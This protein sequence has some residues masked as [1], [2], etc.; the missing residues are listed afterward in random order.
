MAHNSL[1]N[2]SSRWWK[3]LKC[4]VLKTQNEAKWLSKKWKSFLSFYWSPSFLFAHLSFCRWNWVSFKSILFPVLALNE[5]FYNISKR[6]SIPKRLSLALLKWKE[7]IWNIVGE[8]KWPWICFIIVHFF[9]LVFLDGK[10]LKRN[11][12][13][14]LTFY[15][16]MTRDFSM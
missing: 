15:D 6:T 11:F 1:Y 13:I 2:F 16:N 3:N 9:C 4:E 8:N 10:I 12:R 14:N 5:I 7:W